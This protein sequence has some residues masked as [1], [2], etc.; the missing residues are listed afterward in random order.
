MNL[1]VADDE[2][3]ITILNDDVPDLSSLQPPNDTLTYF[4]FDSP[5][6][7]GFG[8]PDFTAKSSDEEVTEEIVEFL[9]QRNHV[10]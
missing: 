9:V 10:Q 3:V 4:T 8:R 2:T 1:F 5:N 6:P 7:L